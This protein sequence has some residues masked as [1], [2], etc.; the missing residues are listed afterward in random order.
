MTTAQDDLTVFLNTWRDSLYVVDNK[1]DEEI[2]AD[3]VTYFRKWI[4]ALQEIKV[5]DDTASA[6][7]EA[8]TAAQRA[9][10]I[11]RLQGLG[12]DCDNSFEDYQLMF[13]D[14]S[15]FSDEGEEL[16]TREYANSNGDVEH[17]FYL[18]NYYQV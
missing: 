4:K 11:L 5:N 9:A 12:Y 16:A 13:S 1:S 6:D 18:I 15:K 14:K 17:F 10:L 8:Y 7:G 3:A 2:I